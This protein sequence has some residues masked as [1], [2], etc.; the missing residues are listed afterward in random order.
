MF[1]H[2]RFEPV[3]DESA[4]EFVHHV[5]FFAG[6]E[7]SANPREC[8]PFPGDYPYF[9]YSYVTN[10]I[11]YALPDGVG[12]N[13][14]PASNKEIDTFQIQVH[15]DNPKE[16]AGFTDSG[17][18]RLYYSFE[19]RPIEVGVM[20]MADP[21]NDLRGVEVG[22]GLS[23]YDFQCKDSRCSGI[24]L[25]EPVTVIREYMHMHANGVAGFQRQ[26]RDGKVIHEAAINFF[27]FDQ[28]GTVVLRDEPF[29]VQAGDTF[30]TEC[31]FK[32]ENGT[33]FGA[34]AEDEMC[35]GFLVYYPAKKLIS[36][37]FP[38]VCVYDAPLEACNAE[39]TVEQLGPETTPIQER[40]FGFEGEGACGALAT[41]PAIPW[42]P[43]SG[44]DSATVRLTVYTVATL[45]LV[46]W[47]AL[48]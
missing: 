46:A 15:Y 27:D 22:D 42:I 4:K 9:V 43:D 45:C 16:L 44:N 21:F 37:K 8:L 36:N 17:G 47:T 41:L 48:M 5:N 34:R 7:S 29:Q 18:V 2:F 20:P 12:Y 6:T 30:Q 35:Q 11:P 40:S 1:C 24:A 13:Y 25:D 28:A 23:H 3:V 26:I 14:G 38:W 33:I 31:Y 32:A 39:L 10:S 19:P